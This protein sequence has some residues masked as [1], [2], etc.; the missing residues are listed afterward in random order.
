VRGAASAWPWAYD[1]QVKL[2]NATISAVW[3]ET[4]R[5]KG[6]ATL[7]AAWLALLSLLVSDFV[8]QRWNVGTVVVQ[9]TVAVLVALFVFVV[10]LVVAV[11]RLEGRFAMA[12]RDF[13]VVQLRIAIHKGIAAALDAC[14]ASD[15][16]PESRLRALA[17]RAV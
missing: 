16:E 9:I 14:V 2:S 17:D 10:S 6:G 3:L 12:K 15:G 4:R 13:E 5:R 8:L 1:A 11:W 7:E